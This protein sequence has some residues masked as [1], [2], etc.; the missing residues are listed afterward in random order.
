[1]RAVLSALSQLDDRYTR[2][3]KCVGPLSSGNPQC[4]LDRNDFLGLHFAVS[5]INARRTE[6][7]DPGRRCIETSD[8]DFREQVTVQMPV[9]AE[10]RQLVSGIV[11]G[12]HH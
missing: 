6:R 5:L 2:T 7:Q 3:W 9:Y 11:Q 8:L 4:S 1:M 12:G 10:Q